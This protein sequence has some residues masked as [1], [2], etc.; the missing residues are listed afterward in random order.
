VREVELMPAEAVQRQRAEGEALLLLDG[1]RGER[2]RALGAVQQRQL[3]LGGRA[4]AALDPA[5]EARA[6]PG[7]EDHRLERPGGSLARDHDALQRLAALDGGLDAVGAAL[8]VRGRQ[9]QV[10]AA[11][12]RQR[13]AGDPEALL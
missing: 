2:E 5:R 1:E 12:V 9:R 3:G 11:G 10:V 4:L 13:E 8:A 6:G 7:V